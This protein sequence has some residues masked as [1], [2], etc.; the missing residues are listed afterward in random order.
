MVERQSPSWGNKIVGSGEVH[1]VRRLGLTS[2]EWEGVNPEGSARRMFAGERHITCVKMSP[3]H[4]DE[5]S[6][7]LVNKKGRPLIS[8]KAVVSFA[9][10][11]T[12]LFSIYD[13]PGTSS[14]HKS[15]SPIVPSGRRPRTAFMPDDPT[16]T[17]VNGVPSPII[18]RSSPSL[19]KRR[20]SDRSPVQ[21]EG[22]SAGRLRIEDEEKR[23][24]DIPGSSQLAAASIRHSAEQDAIPWPDYD[25]DDERV[26]V[27]DHLVEGSLDDLSGPTHPE[28]MAAQATTSRSNAA[29][30]TLP[31]VFDP[32]FMDH[33]QDARLSDLLDAG[34]FELEAGDYPGFADQEA[35][36]WDLD[37][38][39]DMDLD[40]QE[41]DFLE[42]DEMDEDDFDE[43]DED[44][45]D[46]EGPLYPDRRSDETEFG[47]VE[48]I[49]PRRMFKGAKNV[50][51]VKDC[52]SSPQCKFRSHCASKLILRQATS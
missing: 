16:A 6:H 31:A 23:V 17:P 24:Q 13:S 12:S 44:D 35:D 41:D 7:V 38:E 8:F 36:D 1:C 11:S 18:I 39:S 30:P 10:H 49:T 9:R 14:V 20:P 4:A 2:D 25:E 42:D 29:P 19:G 45:E 48:M 52:K 26:G 28:L 21:A 34:E 46:D 22:I 50:E 51:T 37:V 47:G 5:V 40:M 27:G 43:D 3:E 32:D 15:A 33:L